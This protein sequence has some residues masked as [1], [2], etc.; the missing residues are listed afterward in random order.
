M[1]QTQQDFRTLPVVLAP[2][3]VPPWTKVPPP[4]YASFEAV[5]AA[6]AAEAAR[7]RPRGPRKPTDLTMG[8]YYYDVRNCRAPMLRLRGLW[9]EEAGLPI[10][11]RLHIN[12][13]SGKLTLTL[14]SL[15]PEPEPRKPKRKAPW[16]RN[17]E[18]KL[19]A[20]Q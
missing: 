10:G 19:A 6:I 3:E 16:Q 4:G 17:L 15:P 1:D 9:L 11:S 20:V 12:I 13:E 18:Q 14:L 8:S 5:E 7:H 2:H